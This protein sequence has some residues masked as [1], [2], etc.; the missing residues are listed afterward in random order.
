MAESAVKDPIDEA[1]E[2]QEKVEASAE[3]KAP[4]KAKKEAKAKKDAKKEAS[5]EHEA[6]APFSDP[7]A[8]KMDFLTFED[9]EG[10]ASDLDVSMLQ[11]QQQ[12]PF[13]DYDSRIIQQRVYPR[14]LLLDAIEREGLIE[15]IRVRRYIDPTRMQVQ[16]DPATRDIARIRTQMEHKDLLEWIEERETWTFPTVAVMFCAYRKIRTVPF[17]KVVMSYERKPQAMT[18]VVFDKVWPGRPGYYAILPDHSVRAQLLYSYSKRK[19]GKMVVDRRFSFL[20]GD[21]RQIPLL[22]EVFEMC[23]SKKSVVRAL[24][25]A[26][27]GEQAERELFKDDRPQYQN[28]A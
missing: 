14:P 26:S 9:L 22:R 3:K 5:L 24:Q 23:Q 17:S 1:R 13:Y 11:V 16:I 21:K 15:Y 2:Q 6:P 8:K 27:S 25:V 28:F 10:E 19:R 12:H 7:I 18:D 4:A 20:E